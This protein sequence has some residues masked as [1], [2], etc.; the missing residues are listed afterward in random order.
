MAS[1]DHN[2]SIVTVQVPDVVAR[3]RTDMVDDQ[4]SHDEDMVAAQVPDVV[5]VQS[6]NDDMMDGIMG[7]EEFLRDHDLPS[8]LKENVAAILHRLRRTRS[9]VLS[10]VGKK[11]ARGVG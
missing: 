10:S 5:V 11:F 2:G 1:Q 6:S 9:K 7:G 8:N 4:S 3:Q